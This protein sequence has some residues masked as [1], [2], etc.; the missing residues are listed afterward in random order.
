M[1]FQQEL[2]G[3]EL[4]VPLLPRDVYMVGRGAGLSQAE[5]IIAQL[6]KDFGTKLPGLSLAV[7]VMR[8]TASEA[9]ADVKLNYLRTAAE[10]GMDIRQTIE[11]AM[12][13]DQAFLRYKPEEKEAA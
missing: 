6:A 5:E 9:R 13:E 12:E 10:G 7:D 8:M 11:F 3:I 2:D 4:R 1:S